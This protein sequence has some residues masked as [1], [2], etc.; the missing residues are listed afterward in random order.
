MELLRASSLRVEGLGLS[1]RQLRRLLAKLRLSNSALEGM[2]NKIKL[3]SHRAFGFRTVEHYV[4]SIY[5]CCARLP[6]PGES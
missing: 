5:H 2:N 1:E 4:A 6:L 3:V